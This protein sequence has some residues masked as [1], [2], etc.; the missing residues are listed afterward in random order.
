MGGM[1]GGFDK[2]QI[3]SDYKSLIAVM[4]PDM[5]GLRCLD[6]NEQLIFFDEL[7]EIDI[8]YRLMG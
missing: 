3:I 6:R 7:S 2:N 5:F 8:E 1:E 4:L